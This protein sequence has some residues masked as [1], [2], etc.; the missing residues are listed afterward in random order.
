MSSRLTIPSAS[1]KTRSRL[2]VADASGGGGGLGNISGSG[3]VGSHVKFNDTN[4]ITNSTII[5]ENA[6]SVIVAPGKTIVTPAIRVTANPV[7][8]Q[9][10]TS[11]ASGNGTWQAAGGPSSATETLLNLTFIEV[12]GGPTIIEDPVFRVQDISGLKTLKFQLKVS[13]ASTTSSWMVTPLPLSIVP[14]VLCVA[15]AIA[16]NAA[17]N[18]VDPR[19][20]VRLEL[21]T[22]PTP[23]LVLTVLKNNSFPEELYISGQILI[24]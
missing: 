20:F 1:A 5:T 8:G 7:A 18:S 16:I 2:F 14:T 19:T 24:S 21:Q 10:L 12:L 17:S 22:T 11:D 13:V 6:D 15:P 3:A 9:V 4:S 23:R